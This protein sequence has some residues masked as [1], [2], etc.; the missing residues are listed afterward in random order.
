MT[1]PTPTAPKPASATD[2][3]PPRTTRRWVVTVYDHD[4]TVTRYRAKGERHARALFVGFARP[5]GAVYKPFRR[6]EVEER[7]YTLAEVNTPAWAVSK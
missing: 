3:G 4:G 5:G 2:S 1:N 6:V 7:V